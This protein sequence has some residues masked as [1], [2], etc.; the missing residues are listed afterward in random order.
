MSVG[1]IH[2]NPDEWQSPTEFI[3]DRFDPKSKY[4]LTPS[5]QKRHAFSF[6]P[7]IGG[8]RICVGRVFT[9]SCIQVI[10]P[11]IL[12]NFKFEYKGRTDISGISQLSAAQAMVMPFKLEVI[13]E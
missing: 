10:L 13:K 5:G 9:E 7:F 6:I 8:K 4:F 12:L 2:R 11:L 1:A 3:P